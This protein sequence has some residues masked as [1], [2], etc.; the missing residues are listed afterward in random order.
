MPH[1]IRL[2]N[3]GAVG[4]GWP[5]PPGYDAC[6]PDY[7]HRLAGHTADWQSVFAMFR[8]C[9]HDRFDYAAEDAVLR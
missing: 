9:G 5:A 1:P 6:L 2:S 8:N 3:A 4:T 7:L